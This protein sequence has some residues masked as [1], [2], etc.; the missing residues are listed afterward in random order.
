MPAPALGW[1]AL[2]PQDRYPPVIG[3]ASGQPV[4]EPSA[5]TGEL[6]ASPELRARIA[7]DLIDVL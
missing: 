3:H 2:R 5:M 6:I 7:S 1:D 4:T